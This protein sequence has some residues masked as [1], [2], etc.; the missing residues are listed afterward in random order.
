MFYL[1]LVLGSMMKIAFILL[2]SDVKHAGRCVLLGPAE[3]VVRPLHGVTAGQHRN[4]AG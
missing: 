3:L 2:Q 1:H 4:G